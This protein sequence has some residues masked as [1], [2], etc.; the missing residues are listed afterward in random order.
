MQTSRV[1]TLVSRSPR[2]S[3]GSPEP[4]GSLKGDNGDAIT[5]LDLDERRLRRGGSGS[6]EWLSASSPID[7]PAVSELPPLREGKQYYRCAKPLRG[8][9]RTRDMYLTVSDQGILVF[10]RGALGQPDKTYRFEELS[11]WQAT[12]SGG[13]T[14]E[15]MQSTRLSLMKKRN[16]KSTDFDTSP[17]DAHLIVQEIEEGFAALLQSSPVLSEAS[18]LCADGSDESQRTPRTSRKRLPS[19]D[20]LSPALP[21]GGAIRRSL[22]RGTGSSTSIRSEEDEVCPCGCGA[23]PGRGVILPD[24]NPDRLAQFVTETFG[25]TEP[26]PHTDSLTYTKKVDDTVAISLRELEVT[27][28]KCAELVALLPLCHTLTSLDLRDNQIGE[29]GASA[30][31]TILPQ[32]CNLG[33]LSLFANRLGENGASAL[34]EALPQAQSLRHLD[35]TNNSIGDAGA[36][37][38][39]AILPRCHRLET[40]VLHHN[41]IRDDGAQDLALAVEQCAA[42]R[43]IDFVDTNDVSPAVQ[44]ALGKLGKLGALA[45]V[46]EHLQQYAGALGNVGEDDDLE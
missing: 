8:R 32:C 27:D 38:L 5:P 29:P 2:R 1:K 7:D 23:I 12:D 14:A 9:G 34:A 46:G 45:K 11:G 25:V 30:L 3:K 20:S 26:P 19:F 10:Q 17:G 36:H 13:S 22:R 16:G 18:D 31:A 44:A 28:K 21:S 40:L 15:P 4:N 41:G 43:R 37:A 33:S 39:A 42:L 6:S 24:P 35:L